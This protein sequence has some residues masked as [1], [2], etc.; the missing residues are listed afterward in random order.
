[1]VLETPTIE[2]LVDLL[3]IA[4]SEG[5]QGKEVELA[6]TLCK[7]VR[8][9]CLALRH[10]AGSGGA[11]TLAAPPQHRRRGRAEKAAAANAAADKTAE[12]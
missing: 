12:N 9:E 10:A 4:H 6:R 7:D 5:L 2:L 1:M 3:E 11:P 8:A